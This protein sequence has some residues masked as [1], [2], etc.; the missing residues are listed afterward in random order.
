MEYYVILYG[1]NLVNKMARARGKLTGMK[2][3]LGIA[4]AVIFFALFNL[5]IAT[6]YPYEYG[7]DV[8]YENYQQN[9]F[10]IFVVVGLI[11]AVAGMFIA[12]LAFQIVGIGAGT[13]M[14]IE[15][16]V[17]NYQDKIPAFVAL[18]LVFII[19]A[20]FVWRKFRK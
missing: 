2:V 13:A 18:L 14:I 10:Y 4:L 7:S 11:I 8:S 20:I 12:N 17:R 3:F 15:G 19:L 1:G 5:G 6:F 9:I 16:I